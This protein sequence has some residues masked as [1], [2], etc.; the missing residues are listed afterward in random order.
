LLN[1]LVSDLNVA[2]LGLDVLESKKYH[3]IV[4]RTSLSKESKK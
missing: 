4:A 1:E 3:L 2:F